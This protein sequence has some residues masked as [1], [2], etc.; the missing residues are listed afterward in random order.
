MQKTG[1][2]NGTNGRPTCPQCKTPIQL[3]EEQS[4][5]LDVVDHLGRVAGRAGAFVAFGGTCGSFAVPDMHR[6]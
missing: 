1:R 3:K 2:E 4:L 6:C 5:L